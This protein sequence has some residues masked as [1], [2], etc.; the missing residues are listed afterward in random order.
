SVDLL[1]RDAARDDDLPTLA[2]LR[3]RERR[4]G[5][6]RG[7]LLMRLA[8][9]PDSDRLIVG[10]PEVNPYDRA[11]AASP[12]LAKALG[13]FGF[14]VGQPFTPAEPRGEASRIASCPAGR[15]DSRG[16]TSRGHRARISGVR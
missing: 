13:P 8:V 4:L 16:S 2:V 10:D 1:V 15:G 5:D 14:A 12:Q 3:R 11:S 9:V 6:G 7:H